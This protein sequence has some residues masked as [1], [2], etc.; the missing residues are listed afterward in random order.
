MRNYVIASVAKQSLVLV[1]INRNVEIAAASC[2][3]PG[4]DMKEEGR[5]GSDVREEGSRPICHCER[6]R[7]NLS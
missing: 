1:G 2:G 3:R 4:S 5:P 6:K 7:S